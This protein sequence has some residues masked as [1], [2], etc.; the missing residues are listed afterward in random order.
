MLGAWG[1]R[2]CR[3]SGAGAVVASAEATDVDD[4]T[5]VSLGA[6]RWEVKEKADILNGFTK[7]PGGVKRTFFV[8]DKEER[9]IWKGSNDRRVV[10]VEVVAATDNTDEWETR[11]KSIQRSTQT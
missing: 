10:P 2:A 5:L 1:A 8:F 9:A 4:F 6:S 3:I 7:C 11:T